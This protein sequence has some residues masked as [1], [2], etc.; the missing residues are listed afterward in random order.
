MTEIRGRLLLQGQLVP[1]VV[2]FERGRITS[3]EELDSAGGPGDQPIVAPGLV[4]L[5][6][7]GYGG[8][9]PLEGL[10][11]MAAA[12]AAQGT[13]SFLATLFPADPELLGRQ[14]EAVWS[15][16][17][18][19]RAGARV[20]GLHLEGPFVN[21]ARAGGL[22]REGLAAPSPRALRA[23][24]GPSTGAGRGIRALT[25]A[26][27]L[28]G[29]AELVTELARSGIR[30]SLG[31]SLATA[32]DARSA[33]RAGATGVT[34]LF[35]AMRQLHHREAGLVG[36]AL[37]S[38]ALFAEIIGD[39]VHVG[40]EAFQLA[41]RTRGTS[42]LALVSDALAGA[43]TGC[44]VFQSHGKRC[45][46]RDGAIWIADPEDQLKMRLTGAAAAQLEAVRRLVRAGVVSAEEA[47]TLAGESPARAL[48]LDR[49]LGVIAVGA[50]ADLL[51]LRGPEL[52]LAEVWIDGTAVPLAP[53]PSQRSR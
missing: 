47:L 3:V 1:G 17:R 52:E 32:D 43:G 2:E 33:A 22:P 25:L 38:D 44:E 31:H 9:E 27:E 49:E 21:P 7:H 37:S 14:A 11:R 5:H 50:R 13:T 10:K 40:P 36:F 41:L 46:V 24:L 48:G 45:L 34:H 53:G 39:L 20:L 15:T 12:L 6:V 26:P 30:V 19:L 18:D 4:D 8:G 51:V 16:A 28:A 23:I 29:A 35:N 42:G